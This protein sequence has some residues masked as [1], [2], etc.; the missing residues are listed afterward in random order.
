LIEL[1]PTVRPIFGLKADEDAR[2]S[3]AFL[4]HTSLMVRMVDSAINDLGPDTGFLSQLFMDLGSRHYRLG[5]TPVHLL[6][7]CKAIFYCLDKFLASEFSDMERESWQ[8]VLKFIIAK[9]VKGHH[10]AMTSDKARSR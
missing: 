8:V 4:T 5:V 9:M 1:E 10:A 2:S 7:M 6:S 3:E